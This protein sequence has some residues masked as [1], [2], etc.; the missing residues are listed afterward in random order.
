MVC[1][2][3]YCEM[4]IALLKH[5]Q[6]EVD[7][8]LVYLI[9]P[10][11][12]RPGFFHS[13]SFVLHVYDDF[14]QHFLLEKYPQTKGILY[15]F[16]FANRLL[17][18][19]P[20]LWGVSTGMWNCKYRY[21]SE[22]R[23]TVGE[24]ELVYM[25]C[26]RQKADLRKR[27]AFQSGLEIFHRNRILQLLE[28]HSTSKGG[29]AHHLAQRSSNFSSKGTANA[30]FRGHIVSVPPTLLCHCIRKTAT[31][32]TQ[33]GGCSCVPVKLY[34]Q[35]QVLGQIWPTDCTRLTSDLF[36]I[37]HIKQKI[38]VLSPNLKN[39]Y[40]PYLPTQI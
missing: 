31:D 27:H 1:A 20:S 10:V 8:R 2:C 4:A 29:A 30:Y 22:G 7:I 6:P 16:L 11:L 36:Y 37:F 19:Q 5:T 38:F 14:D 34:L 13:Q 24:S 12:L 9:C 39:V 32:N 15:L 28:F 23:L 21:K 18:L 26:R 35:Q 17:F 40:L 25:L 3:N 33:V